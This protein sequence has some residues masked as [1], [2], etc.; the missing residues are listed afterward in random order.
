MLFRKIKKDDI[1]IALPSKNRVRVID[2]LNSY[3]KETWL[4]NYWHEHYNITLPAIFQVAV[5]QFATTVAKNYDYPIYKMCL[6]KPFRQKKERKLWAEDRQHYNAENYRKARK[7]YEI[8]GDSE[9]F[10]KAKE[11][12]RRNAKD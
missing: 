11:E 10:I 6:K 3:V 1:V 2:I 4:K 5:C 9:T 12:M 7:L 8:T